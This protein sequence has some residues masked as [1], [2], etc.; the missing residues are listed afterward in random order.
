[1]SD[2]LRSKI[3]SGVFWQGLCNVGSKGL[4]FVFSIILARLL[5][6][7]DF[8]SVAILMI[9]IAIAEVFVDSGF[10]TALIQKKDADEIDCSSVF[11]INIL[12]A[13]VLYFVSFAAAPWVAE[14][15]RDPKLTIYFRWLALG[16]VIRSLA[17]VQGALLTKRMLFFL[18]FRIAFCSLLVSGVLGISL[19]Y[20]GFGVWALIAQQL[21]SAAVTAI[22]LWLLVRW[23]PRLS[24]VWS[25]VKALFQFGSK[26]LATSLLDSLFNN[27]FGMIVGRLFDLS[28]LAYYNRGRHIPETGMSIINS[29]IGS[30]I[31]PAFAE[32]QDDRERM[33]AIAR[34]SLKL[35][36][37]FVIPAMGM[38]AVLA[39]PLVI[40]LLTE[41]WLSCV[42]FLQLSCITFLVWPLHTLNLQVIMAC[43]RSGIMLILE[44]I[45]KTQTIAILF[46]TYPY[47]VVAMVWGMAINGVVCAVENAWPNRKLIGYSFWP[48]FRDILPLLLVAGVAS[49]LTMFLIV[50]LPVSPWLQLI[51]GGLVYGAVYLT[52]CWAAHTIPQEVFQLGMKVK[53]LHHAEQ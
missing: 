51:A 35:T 49:L 46:L 1:M 37:F 45:K 11:Y 20:C 6:P 15:Y 17:L 18:N 12:V 25:R 31:F 30:V 10:S 26:L 38:L 22:L 19:A 42:I 53:A 44:I 9:F 34:K 7:E 29:T 5:V 32:V 39:R 41:K 52:G 48:Q 33:R 8:G 16:T 24:F 28:T 23:R 40:V 47:G 4:T 43:G 3:L 2:L 50:H 13:V 14:F 36:M 27:L 21:T